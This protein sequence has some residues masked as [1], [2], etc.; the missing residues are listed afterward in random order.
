MAKASL[1]L[2]DGTKVNIQGNS[3][4]VA[5]LLAKFSGST[6][7]SRVT[8]QSLHKKTSERSRSSNQGPKRK[9]PQGLIEEL[10]EENY[11]KARR[12]ISEIQR[13][14]EE[15]GHIY[16]IYALSTPLLRL[17]RSKVLRRIKDK[18]GWVYVQ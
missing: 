4:E 18:K 8:T 5:N 11:F 7:P 16:A 3:E 14:L 1:V 6:G 17:T 9:G 2:P 12:T 13:K 10:V 15:K